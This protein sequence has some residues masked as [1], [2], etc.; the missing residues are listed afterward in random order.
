MGP[1][2]GL[3]LRAKKNFGKGD[4]VVEYAGD[5]LTSER[6]ALARIEKLREIKKDI[7]VLKFQLPQNGKYNWYVG[8]HQIR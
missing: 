8:W 6:E 2:M 1:R 7:Y 3:G 4:F 5:L